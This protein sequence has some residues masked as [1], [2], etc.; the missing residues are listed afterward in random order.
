MIQLEGKKIA[1]VIQATITEKVAALKAEG[2][3]PGLAV[4]LVGEDAASA[5]YVG[6]KEKMAEKLGI[7]SF[8][9]D[10]PFE[11][12]EQQLL[13]LIDKLNHNDEVDGILI[14]LP[15]PEHISENK[16]LF[17][18]DPYKDVDCFHPENIGK[19]L[20]GSQGLL[21][22]TPNGIIQLLKAYDIQISGKN[23]VIIGRSNIVGKPLAQLLLNENATVTVAHSRTKHLNYFTRNA[24]LLFV[25]IG[26]PKFVTAHMV[27]KDAVVVDV[28]INRVHGKLVG[29]VDY[30]NVSKIAGYITPVP[31]GVGPMTIIML[32][33]N[34]IKAC[35]M[36]R[37]DEN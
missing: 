5:T 9:Y 37:R 18:V 28:G 30:D 33:Y 15:L 14:Q 31:G 11:T 10:L 25:A 17:A 26:K 36:R 27:K 1:L 3:H 24:D 4:I 7:R 34:T 16:V 23:A 8:R 35:N 19:M 2:I 21:P 13:E 12:T 22:C 20:L 32:M 29:D 6:S